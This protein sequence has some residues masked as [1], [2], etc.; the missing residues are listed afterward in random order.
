MIYEKD[1][2]V[3]LIADIHDLLNGDKT[4]RLSVI[5][6]AQELHDKL[7]LEYEAERELK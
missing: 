3:K 4:V 6:R 5:V 2:E 7:K 1:L